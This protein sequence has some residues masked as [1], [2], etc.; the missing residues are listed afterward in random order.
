MQAHLEGALDVAKNPFNK[1]Q[2]GLPRGVHIEARLLNG[3][4]NIRMSERQVL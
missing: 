1:I 2:V 4:S 3:M